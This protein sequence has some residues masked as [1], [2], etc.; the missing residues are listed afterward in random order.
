LEENLT[1]KIL[2]V[3]EGEKE[4]RRIIGSTSHGLLSLMGTDYEIVTF[5]NPIYEL[6]DAYKNGEY[7]DLVSYLRIEKGLEFDSNILSK[8]AF[9]A[10]YLV[11]DY[12]I[13]YQKYSDEIIIDLLNTFNNETELGKLYIN[14][15]MVEAFYHLEQLPDN[16]YNERV[17]STDGLIGKDY[18]KLV[19]KVTCLKKIE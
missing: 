11:F 7:D 15:S 4:E 8:S 16:N 14:Y 9:S 12:E 18:K 6:Y 3:V 13:Q 10:I 2:M 19:N 1:S 5:A 17:I